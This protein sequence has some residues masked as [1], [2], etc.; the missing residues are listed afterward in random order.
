M[1]SLAQQRAVLRRRLI[2]R[3]PAPDRPWAD[4]AVRQLFAAG[5]PPGVSLRQAV[6][7]VR[8]GFLPER[9][10]LLQLGDTARRGQLRNDRQCERI[11]RSQKTL[12]PTQDKVLMSLLFADGPDGGAPP[13]LGIVTA[14]HFLPV[15]TGPAGLPGLLSLLDAG[16][17]VVKPSID[18]GGGRGVLIL[19]GSG[20]APSTAGSPLSSSE[21]ER[22]LSSHE[23]S[24]VIRYA[25][26]GQY[27]ERVM[28]GYIGNIRLLTVRDAQDRPHLAWAAHEFV[29][30]ASAPS[31]HFSR[32]GM[33]V[34]IDTAT[35]RLGAGAQLTPDRRV[36]LY[37]HH[38]DTGVR[39]K[40]LTVPHWQRVRRA[41]VGIAAALPQLRLAGWDV[42]VTEDGPVVLEGEA[43][44]LT[45]AVQLHRPLLSDPAVTDFLRREGHLQ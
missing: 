33:S 17:V 2:R 29:T 31:H 9:Y 3:L 14:G 16:A 15:G 6:L 11:N 32:R 40:G 36:E 8:H 7:A 34:E 38:P 12:L 4:A 45:S 19:D 5:R 41:V 35:G 10:H 23:R 42:I 43:H 39:V 13:L 21:V 28:P 18:S 44:A 24:V 22:L 25:R 1:R 27:A 26:Q 30:A 37:D 20:D